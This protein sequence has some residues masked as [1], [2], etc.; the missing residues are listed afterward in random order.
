M[1]IKIETYINLALDAQENFLSY[2]KR[3]AKTKLFM[4]R[5]KTV[6][7]GFLIKIL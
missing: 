3:R 6:L 5:T 4:G 2:K 1:S 7:F